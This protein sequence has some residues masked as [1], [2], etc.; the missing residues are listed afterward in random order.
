MDHERLCHGRSWSF[1]PWY[2]QNEINRTDVFQ[3]LTD[4]TRTLETSLTGKA[5]P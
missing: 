1:G 3:H 2:V 4:D 5:H